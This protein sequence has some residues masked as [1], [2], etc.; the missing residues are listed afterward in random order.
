MT[1]PAVAKLQALVRIPT[2]SR[3]DPALVDN[4]A[5]DTFLAE[6]ADQFP[7]LHERLE[8]TRVHTHALLFRWPGHAD[9]PV[10]LMAHLDVV[11]VDEEAPWQ[12]PA[13]A[14][15]VVDG[16]VWG[17]GTLDDK[18]CLVG[19]CEAVERLLARGFTPAQDVWL[20][21]GADEEVSGQSAP[22]AVEELV[23]RGVRP[24]FVLDEGGA[25]A[26]QAFPG[27]TPPVA[28][29]GVTEKGT[30]TLE[31]TVEGRGGHASTPARMGPPP[32]SPAPS[33]AWTSTRSR[34]APP[35]PPWS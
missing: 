3:P 8:L 15:D 4:G 22:Q 1:D 2:V 16:A 12:H 6:L 10:V 27:V 33:S 23:R 20:S 29:I 34:P 26:H 19:I 32:G 7:L 35:P 11:P 17:R 31:L 18:G 28:V 14:A 9:R 5:F 13:F 30:T 21:F 24:W 25:V